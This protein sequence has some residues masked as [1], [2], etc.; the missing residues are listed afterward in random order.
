MLG[1]NLLSLLLKV[2]WNNVTVK[3]YYVLYSITGAVLLYKSEERH[4]SAYWLFL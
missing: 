2:G 1:I 3:V 4:G